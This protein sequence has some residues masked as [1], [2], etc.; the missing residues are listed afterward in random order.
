MQAGLLLIH[1]GFHQGNCARGAQRHCHL[2]LL[3]SHP[4]TSSRLL[5]KSGQSRMLQM[6]VLVC[7]T[8]FPL[9]AILAI[10]PPDQQPAG[11]RPYPTC[12]LLP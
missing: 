10:C 4:Q 8:S 5:S 7:C 12:H 9:L 6:M 1:D 2:E 3:F 11:W